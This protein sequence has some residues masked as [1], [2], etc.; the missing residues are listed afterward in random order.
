MN[1]FRMELPEIFSGEEGTEF[2]QW[3]Q[4][5]ELAAK[6][7]PGAPDKNHIL[8]PARL[9]GPAF[10]VWA[11]LSESDKKSFDKIKAKLSQVFGRTQYL[12]TFRSCITARK[13][14]FN[15][16]LEVYA[17]A[18]ITMV[19]EAFPNYDADAKEGESFRRFIAGIDQKLQTKIH[20]MGGTTLTEALNIALRVERASQQVPSTTIAST[21]AKPDVYLRLLERLDEMEKKFDKLSFKQEQEK[22]GVQQQRHPQRFSS[23]RD[24]RPRSP[25]PHP[26]YSHHHADHRQSERQ[27]TSRYRSPSPRPRYVSDD[28]YRHGQRHS[29]SSQAG[30]PP[31]HRQGQRFR[32]PSPH[33]EYQRRPPSPR[34]E[35]R[36][37]SPSPQQ[38]LLYQHQRRPDRYDNQPYSYSRR[39]DR[40]SQ[41]YALPNRHVHFADYKPENYQ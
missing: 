29:S 19:E 37:R 10:I 32:S 27:S 5:F 40:Q 36:G 39:D 38:A 26:G 41:E 2:H 18:I 35:Y 8:L 21:E 3:I 1:T 4:R 17:A 31:H 20:E 30:Y 6:I 12:Q 13:R 25:S 23:P 28:D 15:E 14:L 16:S 9:S 33:A 24:N 34:P 11:S 7:I 22:A